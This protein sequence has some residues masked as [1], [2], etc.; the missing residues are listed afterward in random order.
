MSTAADVK[1]KPEVG[2]ILVSLWGYDQTNVDFYKVTKTTDKSVWLKPIKQKIV[3]Q[4]SY[5]S[6]YVVP[7]DE[8]VFDYVY[9]ENGREEVEV[10]ASRY[11]IHDLGKRGYGV[12]ISSFQS[13]YSWGGTPQNQTHYH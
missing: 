4:D 2:D 12:R 1:T 8:P 13:A 11:K 9:T 5:L 7:V 3:E 10:Q 6:E